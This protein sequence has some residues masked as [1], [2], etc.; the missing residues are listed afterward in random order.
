[1][2]PPS[3]RREPLYILGEGMH[4]SGQWRHAVTQYR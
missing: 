2:T 1:M 3:T 4:R